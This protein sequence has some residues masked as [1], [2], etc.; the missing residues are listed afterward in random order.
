[1]S[2]WEDLDFGKIAESVSENAGNWIDT[3]VETYQREASAQPEVNDARAENVTF[4][5]GKEAPTAT[6]NMP[7]SAPIITGID[8]KML[9]AG[10]VGFVALV[11]V[12][13]G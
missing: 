12:V 8:N 5:D 7:Q 1:M 13:K 11:L 10:V 9:L 4:G 2:F 6:V 3:A